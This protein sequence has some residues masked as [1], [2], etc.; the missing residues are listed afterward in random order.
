M[1]EQILKK[2]IKIKKGEKAIDALRSGVPHWIHHT[3]KDDRF[4]D[5]VMYLPQCDCS[6]CG[7]TCNQEKKVCPHC[8]AKMISW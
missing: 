1:T 4:V 7:Y 5:G 3:V 8:G 2:G 6:E